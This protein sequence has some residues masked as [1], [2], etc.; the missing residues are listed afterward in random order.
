VAR[1]T[2]L[3]CGCPSVPS[4]ICEDVEAELMRIRNVE[5]GAFG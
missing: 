1:P 2:P 4:S 3:A 5:A